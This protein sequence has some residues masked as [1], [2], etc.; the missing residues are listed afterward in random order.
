MK[1]RRQVKHITWIDL[2]DQN[3][4]RTLKFFSFSFV[5][6]SGFVCCIFYYM[7]K[8]VCSAALVTTKTNIIYIYIYYCTR[9]TRFLSLVTGYPVIKTRVLWYYYYYYTTIL[10]LF[11]Y[12]IILADQ[13]GFACDLLFIL[14][15]VEFFIQFL[16][17]SNVIG[18]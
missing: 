15:S 18:K 5:C 10:E 1:L 13:H 16:S 6:S 14:P 2:T 12:Y 3:T 9:K 17:F 11:Y 7:L 4:V 8:K